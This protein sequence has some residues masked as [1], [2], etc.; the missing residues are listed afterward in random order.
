MDVCCGRLNSA[1]YSIKVLVYML[2][3]WKDL[4]IQNI[5]LSAYGQFLF[6]LDFAVVRTELKL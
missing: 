6:K 2:V 3:Y 1:F 4:E 5:K